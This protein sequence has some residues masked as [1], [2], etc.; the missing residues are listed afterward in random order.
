VFI[1]WSE[2]FAVGIPKVDAEHRHLVTIVNAFHQVHGSG[3]GRD[4]V[5]PVLNLLVQYVEV[6]FQSEESLM[7]AGKYPDLLKHRREHDKLTEQIFELA[8]RYEAGDA[9]ITYEVMEFL[10]SWLLEHI[11][12]MD[13]KLEPFFRKAGVPQGWERLEAPPPRQAVAAAE[14]EA[15]T[16]SS[17]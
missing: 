16:S 6:H 2:A 4:K 8:E 17:E 15:R 14:L 3:A 13:K 9:E 5:F 11:L 1:E 7:A 10:K 12:Q